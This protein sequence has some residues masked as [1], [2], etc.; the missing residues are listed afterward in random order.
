MGERDVQGGFGY[1]RQPTT[2]SSMS[3]TEAAGAT[4]LYYVMPLDIEPVRLL[5]R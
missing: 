4:I 2:R 3:N 1:H 5:D